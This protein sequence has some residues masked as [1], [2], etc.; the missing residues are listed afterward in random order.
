MQYRKFGKL[1]W[2]VSALGFGC[3]RLPVLDGK[4]NQIDIPTATRMIHS[5]I[6]GG[7]NYIDTAYTY[8]DG[9]S[10]KF[11]GSILTADHR[12][13]V[14]L[15]TK[16]PSWLIKEKGDFD[17]YFGEQLSRLQT[18]RIDF[19]LVHAL[20]ETYWENLLQLG[21]LDWLQKKRD[22]GLIGAIGFSFHDEFR[23]FMRIMDEFD[24]W[25]FCQIQYNYLDVDTQAGLRGLRYAADRGLAVIVMEPLLGGKLAVPPPAIQSI[26]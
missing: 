18:E 15:A 5:G 19:Y 16:M 6:E 21:I 23:V 14:K 26:F 4:R 25:D 3:M 17:L 10:E 9:E 22:K 13:K 20:N 7:I 1:D 11:V 2:T 24:N 12:R 8:H